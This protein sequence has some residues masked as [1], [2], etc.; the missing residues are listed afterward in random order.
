LTPHRTWLS[1]AMI[2]CSPARPLPV[3]LQT[4]QSFS[5][6]RFQFIPLHS[7]PFS[8]LLRMPSRQ[9]GLSCLLTSPASA[10]RQAI[11]NP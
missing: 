6:P 9:L 7:S 11:Q 2:A 8:A 4:K 10:L 3:R 5:A 1:T